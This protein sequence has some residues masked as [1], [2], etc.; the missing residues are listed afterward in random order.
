[1]TLAIRG[2]ASELQVSEKQIPCNQEQQSGQGLELAA[3]QR[4]GAHLV[5]P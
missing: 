1:M 2:L 3:A 5:L 4:S